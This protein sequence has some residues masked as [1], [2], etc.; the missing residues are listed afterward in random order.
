[1]MMSLNGLLAGMIATCSCCNVIEVW[2]S[3][4]VGTTGAAVYYMQSYVTEHYFHVDDP[5]D[6]A[7]LHMVSHC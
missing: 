2:A 3:L 7:A 1:M 6:A 4:I 5:L